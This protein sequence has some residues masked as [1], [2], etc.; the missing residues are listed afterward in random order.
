[1]LRFNW[2]SYKSEYNPKN[3][4]GGI[5]HRDAEAETKATDLFKEEYDE[6]IQSTKRHKDGST[7]FVLKSPGTPPY[8]EPPPPPAY[9]T[10]DIKHTLLEFES[11]ELL[12]RND[13]WEGERYVIVFFNK[14]VNYKGEYTDERSMRLQ[15]Q[16]LQ[17]TRLLDVQQGQEVQV[18]RDALLHEL[19]RTT[20]S[21]DRVNSGKAHSKYGENTALNISL[22]NTLSRSKGVGGQRVNKRSEG[23]NNTKYKDLYAKFREYM[24]AFA[25]GVFTGEDAKYDMCIIAKDSQCVWHKDTNNIGPAALTALG[26]FTGGELLVEKEK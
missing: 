26:D 14:D 4:E 12:H 10:H 9:D 16:P 20:F 2:F 11:S 1:V 8:Q 25:P 19:E 23:K 24:G 22:G 15:R 17:P 3:T 21:P 6:F 5:G 13:P 18:Q 7:S